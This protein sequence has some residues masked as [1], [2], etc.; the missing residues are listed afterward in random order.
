MEAT[1]WPK[2]TSWVRVKGYIRP[3]WS[4]LNFA[5]GDC[6]LKIFG[7]LTKSN[8]GTGVYLI[9]V[10]SQINSDYDSKLATIY[11]NGV[12]FSDGFP[13]TKLLKKYDPEFKQIRGI[14]LMK[15]IL[16][17][18][19]TVYKHFFLGSTDL[20]LNRIEERLTRDYPLANIAGA[21]SPPF[22]DS[23]QNE[24]DEWV[25]KIESCEANIIWVGMGS[26]KQDFIVSEIVT[27]LN[28][29]AIG[30][31]AAF[32]YLSG[33]DTEAPQFL[34]NAGL[35]WLYRWF[36]EPLRLSRRYIYSNTLFLLRYS[37]FYFISN[38]NAGN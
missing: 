27:R 15:A 2:Y 11:S 18:G 24:I 12:C 28:V 4:V 22:S 33:L 36:R 37:K 38:F 9:N 21:F 34:R 14:D 8:F 13:L 1:L 26:P 35:E 16:G 19:N 20:N 6:A 25:D 7:K 10:S 30:V 32:N 31:G 23:W 29:V 17:S 5:S 3:I